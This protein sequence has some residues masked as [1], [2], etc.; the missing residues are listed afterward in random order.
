M[1]IVSSSIFGI[2]LILNDYS[3]TSYLPFIIISTMVIPFLTTL[4]NHKFKS[5][6]LLIIIIFSLLTVIILYLTD[7][8]NINID[9]VNKNKFMCNYEPLVMASV[10]FVLIL[11][12][13]R[14]GRN[15]QE[16]SEKEIKKLKKQLKN[17]NI[18]ISTYEKKLYSFQKNINKDLK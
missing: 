1:L 11:Y 14:Y 10:Y 17:L 7:L 13:Y 4:V 8:Q 18:E 2:Y 12:S 9:C 3:E 5:I 6:S 15:K 16:N